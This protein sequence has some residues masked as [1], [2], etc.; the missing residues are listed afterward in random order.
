MVEIILNA[1]QNGK[2][3][4]IIKKK[5]IDKENW[6]FPSGPVVNI[7]PSSARGVGSIPSWEAKI[8]HALGRKNQNIKLKQY[9][10]KFNKNFQNGHIK[11]S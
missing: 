8:P 6:D 3:I 10:N 11:K 1:A 2:E 5:I 9:F 7:L 4:E